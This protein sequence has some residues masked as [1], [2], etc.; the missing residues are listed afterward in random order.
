MDYKSI[1]FIP[2]D[3]AL[4]SFQHP[5]AA[6]SRRVRK[7]QQYSDS[8]DYEYSRQQGTDD[9]CLY[10]PSCANGLTRK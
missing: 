2:L 3:L 7:S 1:F 10:S 8:S 5:I 9:S 4:N 6:K